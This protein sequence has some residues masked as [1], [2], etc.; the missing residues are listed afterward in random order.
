MLYCHSCL[1]ETESLLCSNCGSDFVEEIEEINEIDRNDEEI[2]M[3]APPPNI[4]LG[5]MM[6]ARQSSRARNDVDRTSNQRSG[7]DSNPS[8]AAALHFLNL[9]ISQLQSRPIAT[10]IS[11]R[12]RNNQR[13][14]QSRHVDPDA[15]ALQENED[16]EDA[17]PRNMIMEQMMM[18]IGQMI[19]D[20]S[21]ISGLGPEEFL[22]TIFGAAPGSNPGDYVI[23][24]ERLDALM[25]QLMEANENA[26]MPPAADQDVLD[27]L[28]KI[29]FS[30]AV[31]EHKECPVCQ[32]DFTEGLEL[33][34]LPCDHTFHPTC[35]TSWL[36]I[37]G[38][39]PVCRYSLVQNAS[40]TSRDSPS[41]SRQSAPSSST[42]DVTLQQ[43]D[44][45]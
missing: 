25:T 35:I 29:I 30:N 38:T 10:P 14:S 17:D 4:L 42:F 39:C 19:G 45:D 28:P 32:D 27:A 13:R 5:L 16:Q 7:N 21:R 37:N 1:A 44:V 41:A 26:N 9:D 15:A 20:N 22:A 18:H 34:K 3:D 43:P 23:G 31:N 8:P 33:L 2:M 40:A 6:A 36:K 24:Q 12:R 11:R